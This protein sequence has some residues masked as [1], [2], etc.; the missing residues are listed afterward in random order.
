[1]LIFIFLNLLS[2]S[3]SESL[4]PEQGDVQWDNSSQTEDSL[5]PV[6]MIIDERSKEMMDKIVTSVGE[7]PDFAESIRM[8]QNGMI[9]PPDNIGPDLFEKA[10]L[11][12]HNSIADYYVPDDTD[13]RTIHATKLDVSA[14]LTR[15][16]NILKWTD[17]DPEYRQLLNQNAKVEIQNAKR[18]KT[19]IQELSRRNQGLLHDN[20]LHN[21]IKLAIQKYAESALE[22][23][24]N[25]IN[26]VRQ[27][28]DNPPPYI[29]RTKPPQNPIHTPTPTSTRV[30]HPAEPTPPPSSPPPIPPP[31]SSP[32]PPPPSLTS[33][34]QAE[35]IHKTG[36]EWILVILLPIILFLGIYFLYKKYKGQQQFY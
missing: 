32:P 21:H 7:F 23:I 5:P 1:M 36:K 27:L 10:I 2:F 28:I 15:W 12:I 18:C 3:P 20:D 6:E 30:Q 19:H 34:N 17:Y 9:D 4:T 16:A 31:P 33:S 35:L 29:P 8:V 22:E 25:A 11:A 26:A 24:D 13:K 14:N